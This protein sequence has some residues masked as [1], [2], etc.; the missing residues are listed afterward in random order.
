MC[1][2][3][4]GAI[5]D[6]DIYGLKPEDYFISNAE[7]ESSTTGADGVGDYVQ[8]TAAVWFVTVQQAVGAQASAAEESDGA[9]DDG[10]SVADR[11]PPRGA[12][13]DDDDASQQS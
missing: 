11:P 13:P 9:D 6:V 10:G 1:V 3:A 5:D 2:R 7:S 4:G 8:R 12:P